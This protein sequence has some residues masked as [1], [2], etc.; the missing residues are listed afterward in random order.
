MY[1]YPFINAYNNLPV[2]RE[3]YLPC[4]SE[5]TINKIFQKTQNICYLKASNKMQREKAHFSLLSPLS[6]LSLWSLQSSWRVQCSSNSRY[7]IPLPILNYFTQQLL[8]EKKFKNWNF[9]IVFLLECQRFSPFSSKISYLDL[10]RSG[11]L[12]K[13]LEFNWV[14][15]N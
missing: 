12:F 5:Q 7:L 4:L 1:F 14:L 3:Y 13:C 2:R 6:S 10:L 11:F 8:Q 9:N 15:F